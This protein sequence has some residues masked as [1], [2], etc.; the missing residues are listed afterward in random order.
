M[1]LGFIFVKKNAS[2]PG[3]QS[4]GPRSSSGLWVHG[5]PRAVVAEGL[6]GSRAR[7]RFGDWKLT[8][9]EEKG[10]PGGSY[11]GSGCAVRCRREA[12]D[13]GKWNTAS[14]LGVGRLRAWISGARWGKTL[15]VKWPWLRAPFI[16]SRR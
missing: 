13:G 12:D 6:A 7:G 15:W 5:G 10:S 11:R 2:G 16:A 4:G 9:G 14:V 8:S 3:A 1:D